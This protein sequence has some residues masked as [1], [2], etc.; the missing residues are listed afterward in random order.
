MRPQAGWMRRVVSVSTRGLVL[1]ALS[2]GPA[3]PES[4]V[5][6]TIDGREIRLLSVR[7]VRQ[8]DGAALLRMDFEAHAFRDRDASRREAQALLGPLAGQLTG[9]NRVMVVA[10][11]E[12][13][14]PWSEDR[15]RLAFVF[16]R[17]DGKWAV[18]EEGDPTLAQAQPE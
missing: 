13:P 9:R 8:R 6:Q 1:L 10:N 18:V 2:C 17:A 3:L 14:D 12:R 11:S 5:V 4:R 15:E 16:E 7:D